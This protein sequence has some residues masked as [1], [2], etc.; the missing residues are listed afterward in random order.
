MR[1]RERPPYGR[2]SLRDAHAFGMHAPGRYAFFAL[3]C[4]LDDPV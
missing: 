2:A 4:S 3:F 1:R